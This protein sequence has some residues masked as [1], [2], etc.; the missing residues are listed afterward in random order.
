MLPG[1][2]TVSVVIPCFNYARFLPFSVNSALEQSG[3]SVEVIIVDDA[4]TDDSLEQ[5]QALSRKDNRVRVLGH[6]KNTGPVGTF[7]D[8]L[9]M[10]TGEFLVRL[11]ADDALTPGSLAR[12]VHLA[13]A[14]PRV[15]L[16]YGHP[17]HFEGELRR[18]W[19]RR[20]VRSWIVWAGE[21]WLD[22]RCVLGVNCI[23]S[24]EVLM[25]TSVVRHVGG[26]RELAHT[27]DMEMWMRI[28]R[29]SDVGWIDGADQAWHREHS[30]SLSARKVDLMTDLDERAAAF[31]ML[32]TDGEGHQATASRRLETSLHAVA[33]E[34]VARACQAFVR[35]RGDSAEVRG[36]LE[37]A[38]T[39]AGDLNRLPH[40]PTLQKSMELGA[41]GSRRSPVLLARAAA[42]R[43]GNDYRRFRWKATGL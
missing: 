32:F 6:V 2:A 35:G 38:R 28:A 23:T 33:N 25:R 14:F 5:A 22:Y 18:P 19:F 29:A 4:S 24:P 13:Q 7:N 21:S 1:A 31:Q 26:Q 16:V 39:I 36:Y 3:V 27:H 9:A 17:I 37:F 11:D 42:Y 34:A 8:G 20:K 30:G 40:G 15:G 43:L 10:A 12:A 41:S